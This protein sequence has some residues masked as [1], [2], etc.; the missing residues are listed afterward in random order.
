VDISTLAR[1]ALEQLRDQTEETVMLVVR[2]GLA[3][4]VAQPFESRQ[5]VRVTAQVGDWASLHSSATG[6]LFLA[7]GPAGLIEELLENR[8]ERF[9]PNTITSAVALRKAVAQARRRGWAVDDEE[10]VDGIRAVAAPVLR[11]D[12]TLV[13]CV[14]VRAPATRLPRARFP[15]LAAQVVDAATRLSAELQRRDELGSHQVP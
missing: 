3:A 8:L 5:T 15:E 7:Y 12:E 11:D 9:T 6:K 2:R 4:I 1:P 14:A 13:A 10:F